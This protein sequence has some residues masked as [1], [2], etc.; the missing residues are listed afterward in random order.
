MKTLLAFVFFTLLVVYAKGQN[1][2]FDS[3]IIGVWKGTSLC[4]QKN[5]SCHDE[6]AVY[7]I[8]KVQGID[9][10]NIDGKRIVNGKEIDMGILGCKLD[11]K[12]K[13]LLSTTYGLWTFNFKGNVLDGTLYQNGELFRIVKLTKMK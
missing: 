2:N 10:F 8:V 9:T 3:S 1:L 13:R 12:N 11:R 4:Q 5:S 6:V 7:Y